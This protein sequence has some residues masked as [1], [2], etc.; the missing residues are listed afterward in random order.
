MATLKKFTRRFLLISNIIVVVLFLMA[1]ANGFLH[2]GKWWPVSLLGLIFPLLLLLV[3]AFFIGWLFFPG[4]R[5][6]LF[7]LG[8]L[9]LGWK[10]IH[11]FLAF[12]AGVRFT[13]EKPANALR[14]LTWNVR[15]WDE[16]IPKKEY[17]ILKGATWHFFVHKPSI[18]QGYVQTSV[19]RHFLPLQ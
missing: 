17:T 16:I 15:R 12:N 14:I 13:T 18:P 9:V 10:N 5:W 11:S 8:A 3:L 7:S 4:R 1:C 19:I 2:P 6:A